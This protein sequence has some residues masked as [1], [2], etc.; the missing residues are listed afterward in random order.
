MTN[1]TDQID[2]KAAVTGGYSDLTPKTLPEAVEVAQRLLAGK[3]E[4]LGNWGLVAQAIGL[5][6]DDR[7]AVHRVWAHGSAQKKVLAALGL[8]HHFVEAVPCS[9][10]GQVHT[11]KGC[12]ATY[13]GKRTGRARVEADLGTL[14]RRA[15]FRRHVTGMGY[16]S[17]THYLNCLVDAWQGDR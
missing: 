13:D 8:P 9:H 5:D 12:T 14:E 11:T 1:D 17:V 4:N 15:F 6:Y 3:F 16:D 10:C 2:G 7:A